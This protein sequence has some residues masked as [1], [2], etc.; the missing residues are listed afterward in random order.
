MSQVTLAAGDKP[1][2]AMIKEAERIAKLIHA[3]KF[4]GS[5]D[6]K[7]TKL[8]S[9]K[10]LQAVKE[11][12]GKDLSQVDYDSPDHN[13][14]QSLEKNVY[15]FSV[16]KN[17]QQLKSMSLA[18]KDSDGKIR[19]FADFKNEAMKVAETYLGNYL[20]IEY[21][22]AVGSAQM[23]A[24]WVQFEN[25]KDAV[26]MLRYVTA[27]DSRVRPAHRLLDGVTREVDDSFWNYYYPPNGWNCRC[28]VIQAIGGRRTEKIEIP[29]DDDV[30]KIFRTNMAKEGLVFPADHPYFIG[31][32]DSV[33]KQADVL[34]PPANRWKTVEK[35]DNGGIVREN[36]M[37]NKNAPDYQTVKNI[38][39]DKAGRG[40]KVDIMPDQVNDEQLSNLFKGAKK[41]VK[42]DLKINNKFVEVKTPQ[43]PLSKNN[44]G[45]NI[46]R[47]SHQADHVIIE[48]K[49][50][51]NRD[52]LKKIARAKFNKYADLKVIEY[53]M[54]GKYYRYNKPKK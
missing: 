13:M 47:A 40:M 49:A 12:F 33:L 39:L 53:K 15:E 3:G 48:L 52:E 43:L 44:I 14:L 23:A 20:R 6:K 30:P 35:F 28:D 8:V 5:I 10:L 54:Q 31:I 36:E 22:T 17:Y 25:D 19:S 34:L 51:F 37:V 4:K 24:K 11:G 18:L 26:S 42:P 32:P 9:Q 46:R 50:L 38:A 45:Q 29:G 21:D 7:L 1:D 41:N 2:A 16:A 27:G